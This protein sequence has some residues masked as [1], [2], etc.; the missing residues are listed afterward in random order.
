M[1]DSPVE[2]YGAAGGGFGKAG[3]GALR[4][5]TEARDNLQSRAVA[6][7]LDLLSE[8]EIEGLADGYKSIYFDD[9]PLQNSK[10][11][12]N[13]TGY[14]VQTRNGSNSQT[15]I[16]GFPAV[17]RVTAVGV[18]IQADNNISG[19][20]TR[21]WNNCNFTRSAATIT[22]G[23]TGHGMSTSNSVFLNFEKYNG[24]HDALYTVTV[25]DANTFTVQRKNA[26]FKSAS[27]VVYAIK[28]YLK[29]TATGSIA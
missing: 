7:V 21:D 23:W 19:T 18:E 22:I 12:N 5:A 9:T 1:T 17:E 20:W 8:G 3:G 6:R 2:I 13:F 25:V 28:P 24:V 26:N 4:S 16:A 29:I 15:Y 10:G 27:G 14:T 11:E